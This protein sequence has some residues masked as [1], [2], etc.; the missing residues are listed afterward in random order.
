M[1]R[2]CIHK[3]KNRISI[4]KS[5]CLKKYIGFYTASILVVLSMNGLSQQLD[6]QYSKQQF[7]RQEN[8]RSES[9]QKLHRANG[10]VPPR[11]PKNRK[12]LSDDDDLLQR[13]RF[14]SRQGR[15]EAAA[16]DGDPLRRPRRSY[17]NSP[18]NRGAHG[19]SDFQHRTKGRNYYVT[20]LFDLNFDSTKFYIS[21]ND[22]KRLDQYTERVLREAKQNEDPYALA[23]AYERRGRAYQHNKRSNLALEHL[24]KGMEIAEEHGFTAILLSSSIHLLK[25]NEDIL[26]E[27]NILNTIEFLKPIAISGEPDEVS[28]T[29]GLLAQS[30]VT[31]ARIKARN[32]AHEQAI[33]YRHQADSVI[34]FAASKNIHISPMTTID[35][36]QDLGRCEEVIHLLKRHIWE[37][38]RDGTTFGYDRLVSRLSQC[39]LDMGYPDSAL[40]LAER[41][42]PTLN[43]ANLP[44]AR[45]R[46]LSKVLSATYAALG[47]Y[48]HAYFWMKESQLATEEMV[49]NNIREITQEYSIKYQTEKKEI[50]LNARERELVMQK[51]TILW[52]ILGTVMVILFTLFVYKNYLEKKKLSVQLSNQNKTITKQAQELSDL[53]KFK[54]GLT[55]MIV[56]DLKNPLSAIIEFAK[57]NNPTPSLMNRIGNSGKK[58]LNMVLNILDIQ[59][60]EEAEMHPVL[61][62][63]SLV[64]LVKQSVEQVEYLSIQ[65]HVNIL[66]KPN[67][68]Y[69]VNVD[70]DL[71]QRVLI[72][73]LSNAIKY[74]NH[75]GQVRVKTT[76][77]RGFVEISIHDDGQGIPKEQLP[78]VF[79]KFWQLNSQKMGT[80]RSVGLGLT[81]CKL[82]IESQGGKIDID[83]D[84][85]EGTTLYFTLP[86]SKNE[87]ISMK[88]E[89][90]TLPARN[91]PSVPLT[92][93]D[94]RAL[95]KY[96]VK[97]EFKRVHEMSEI[98][99][100]LSEIEESNDSISAW[101]SAVENA[102]MT[103][104]EA[105]Y[106]ELTNKP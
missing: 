104:N 26:S 24:F 55:A 31:L 80:V 71:T 1:S 5:T 14:Q 49:T 59:K 68:D 54:E 66:F 33:K 76:L 106:Q 30:F 15:P 51:R 21:F 27:K 44:D 50:E 88:P 85:G 67:L 43:E 17:G 46:S 22:R 23:W 82:A 42:I 35:V 81:F 57:E 25:L 12:P 3:M 9:D 29:V 36:Y 63:T 41:L 64:S 83:S 79:R 52:L 65:H 94:H 7:A 2:S 40:A 56:H 39:Y 97:L 58:M 37:R 18:E 72:N 16:I 93:S 20:P 96:L 91:D 100:I 28:H 45:K 70:I 10:Q 62:E 11:G 69:K 75:N 90:E 48:K 32:K 47:Q 87:E 102:V 99:S 38:E 98:L 34:E 13:P 78:N 4:Q 103:S 92:A 84:F 74:S 89:E 8:G 19:K 53:S 73:I 61:S 77:L 105:L 86:V 60:F 101:K 6:S 95:K